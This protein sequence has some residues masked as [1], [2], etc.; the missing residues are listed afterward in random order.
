MTG[1]ET[2]KAVAAAM[3]VAAQQRS[4]LYAFLATIYRAEPTPA[5]LREI[6]KPA[7]RDAL[8]DAGVTW[9]GGFLDRPEEQLLTELA[10]EYTN[11]FIGPGKHLSP[12]EAA[13][14]EGALWGKATNE[15]ARIIEASGLRY[16]PQFHGLP[17]HISVELEFMADVVQREARAW[18]RDDRDVALQCRKM[19]REFLELHICRW[20]PAFCDGVMDKARLPFY[21]EM[22]KL[23]KRFIGFERA[24]DTRPGARSRSRQRRRSP[25]GLAA[26]GKNC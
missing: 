26:V 1:T 25:E 15:V 13:Q 8:S 24:A 20:V 4:G 6:G 14:L 7:F 10:V 22:A 17:D 18:Q 5:L 21:R 23:T 11:L 3:A 19:A 9:D 16:V 2:A 12:H